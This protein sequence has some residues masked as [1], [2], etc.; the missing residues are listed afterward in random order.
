MSHMTENSAVAKRRNH[1]LLLIYISAKIKCIHFLS[2]FQIR[3]FN[4]AE[5]VV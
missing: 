4:F 3:Q 1:M 2:F 5:F